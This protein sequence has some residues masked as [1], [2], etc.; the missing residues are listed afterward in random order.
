MPVVVKPSTAT[1]VGAFSPAQ[2]DVGLPTSWPTAGGGSAVIVEKYI[3]G[4]E[5]RLL[6]VGRRV[7]AP[8]A[9]PLGHGDGVSTIDQLAD[10]QIN[11]PRR[12]T[13]E[14]AL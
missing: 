9:N 5:H 11:D 10:A 2:S 6:V 14:D 12:G 1:M 8:S 4:N 3:P 13:T 7:V